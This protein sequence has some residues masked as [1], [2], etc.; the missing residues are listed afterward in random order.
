MQTP[1]RCELDGPP[2]AS[3]VSIAGG[4]TAGASTKLITTFDHIGLW[5]N[6]DLW[7]V[8]TE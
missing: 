6:Y 5:P 3:R 2:Q 8:S 4:I 7:S 1:E